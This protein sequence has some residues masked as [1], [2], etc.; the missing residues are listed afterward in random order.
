MTTTDQRHYVTPDDLAALARG[1]IY[2]SGALASDPHNF[3]I[4]EAVDERMRRVRDALTLL[5]EGKPYD[6]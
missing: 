2:A 6:S 4:R 3:A 1:L 5:L